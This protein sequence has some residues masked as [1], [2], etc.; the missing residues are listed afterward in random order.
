MVKHQAGSDFQHNSFISVDI[1]LPGVLSA[2]GKKNINCSL[3]T[4]V[5]TNF[6]E[7]GSQ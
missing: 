7:K 3:I 2:L 1:F 4:L 5:W 6:E